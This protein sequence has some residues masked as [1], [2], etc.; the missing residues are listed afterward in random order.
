MPD[1]LE[2][3][4]NALLANWRTFDFPL[5]S[6]TVTRLGIYYSL[7][8]RWNDRLH[9]VAPC[10]PEEFATRHVLESLMLLEHLPHGAKIADIGSGGG[11]PIIPCLVARPDL[12][13]TLIESSQ[14]KAVFLRE[15]LKEVGRKATII[16]RRF[17]DIETPDVQF[18]T[19][20]ALDQFIRKIPVLLDWAPDGATLLLF[21][22]EKLLDAERFLIPGSE[23]RYLY[24][25]RDSRG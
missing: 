15:A 14:K 5:S 17:E 22:G 8:T 4:R 24:V 7:L 11:L 2:R 1:E 25:K 16:A 23:K 6:D 18:V 12:E 21:G 19:S 10:S 9:L 13:A 20:R 3:F